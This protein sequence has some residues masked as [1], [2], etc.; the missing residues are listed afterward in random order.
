MKTFGGF[1]HIACATIAAATVISV[2][3]IAMADEIATEDLPA[4]Q[5]ESGETVTDTETE[6][7]IAEETEEVTAEEQQEVPETEII[8]EVVAEDEERQ[9]YL[10]MH[11]TVFPTDGKPKTV[12]GTTMLTVI[13]LRAGIRSEV[14]GIT[15]SVTAR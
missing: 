10:K 4:D 5:I 13:H 7:V 15:S 9:L 8:D 1:K 6:A 14:N 11:H 12:S 3:C 2:G